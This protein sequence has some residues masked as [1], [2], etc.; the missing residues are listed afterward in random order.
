MKIMTGMRYVLLCIPAGRRLLTAACSLL[1]R[2]VA[3]AGSQTGDR[4]LQSP[5]RIEQMLLPG[6]AEPR[7]W[8]FGSA[9]RRSGC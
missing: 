5:A 4:V 6:I 2:L 8:E 7:R 1:E 9:D 3:D